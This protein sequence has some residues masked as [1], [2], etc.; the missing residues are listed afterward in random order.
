MKKLQ[1]FI[2]LL[3]YQLHFTL[4][5]YIVHWLTVLYSVQFP[6]CTVSC[7]Y[8][9]LYT[10]IK[11]ALYMC[12]GSWNRVSHTILEILAS[13]GCLRHNPTGHWGYGTG[14]FSWTDP[15]TDLPS[16][17]STFHPCAS[18]VVIPY[19]LSW[20]VY[21][22]KFKNTVQCTLYSTQY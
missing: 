13:V 22:V 2:L 19:R 20:Y 11:C 5:V 6:A 15:Q 10:V 8:S 7:V 1:H 16:T 4:T 3:R 12:H 18:L 17:V 21:I 14:Q 9:F